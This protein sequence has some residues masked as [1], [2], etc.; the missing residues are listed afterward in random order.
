VSKLE[1]FVD[2]SKISARTCIVNG[3]TDTILAMADI[4]TAHSLIPDSEMH[5]IEG[6]GH[7]LHFEKPELME[8]YEEFLHTGSIHSLAE[9]AAS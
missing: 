5:I 8:L 2:L 3:S 9:S 4:Y 6:V 1:E 7:F